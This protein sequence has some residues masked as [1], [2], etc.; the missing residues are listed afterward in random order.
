MKKASSLRVMIAIFFRLRGI[1]RFQSGIQNEEYKQSLRCYLAWENS[2]SF[3]F[4]ETAIPQCKCIIFFLSDIQGVDYPSELRKTFRRGFARIRAKSNPRQIAP[5]E[6]SN[7]PCSG[8]EVIFVQN[9]INP[10]D[11]RG[12]TYRSE[13]FRRHASLQ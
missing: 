4:T 1:Q 7:E 3:R 12:L 9:G 5:K 6:I 13:N 10:E 8:F 11:Y 2:V